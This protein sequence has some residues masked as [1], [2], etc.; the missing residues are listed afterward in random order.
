MIFILKFKGGTYMGSS[1]KK[2]LTSAFAALIFVLFIFVSSVYIIKHTDH[3]C[4][5]EDCPICTEL[6]QLRNTMRSLDTG[7]HADVTTETVAA[8]LL[9]TADILP[10]SLV[11]STPV[12]LKVRLLN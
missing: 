3:H 10:L 8:V 4:T 6:S 11:C 12:S 2:R 9:L 5:G 1:M 7:A